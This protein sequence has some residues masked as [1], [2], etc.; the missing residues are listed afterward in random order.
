MRPTVSRPMDYDMTIPAIALHGGALSDAQRT[1]KH[2]PSSAD[3]IELPSPLSD[4]TDEQ[5]SIS[6]DTVMLSPPPAAARRKLRNSR[7][8]SA[9]DEYDEAEW[10]P[11]YSAGHK[12]RRAR[13]SKRA[14]TAPSL[15]EE[16]PPAHPRR[17]EK[18][19]CPVPGCSEKHT[20]AGDLERHVR[21][22]DKPHHLQ[23]QV[24]CTNDVHPPEK[25]SRLDNLVP[26]HMQKG[27][28]MDMKGWRK[29]IQKAVK[30]GKIAERP[31]LDAQKVFATRTYAKCVLHCRKDP[32]YEVLN[33]EVC[34]ELNFKSPEKLE[35]HLAEETEV[36]FRCRCCKASRT[37][38]ADA[39][40]NYGCWEWDEDQQTLKRKSVS[41]TTSGEGCLDQ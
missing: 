29:F 14:Q 1:R 37:S 38:W 18:L 34:K 21:F 36:I 12:P 9:R 30:E 7:P 23:V 22:V 5:S 40:D 19:A 17:G 31:H 6:E 4:A 10:K 11:P 16:E 26:R 27:K 28:C 8:K 20:R 24:Y 41:A 13:R 2:D 3:R 32:R 25:Q 15:A 39:V 33:H 35:Q